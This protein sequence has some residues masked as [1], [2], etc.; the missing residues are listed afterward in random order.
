MGIMPPIII[1]FMPPIMFMGI[2]PPI[3]IG[4][5]PPI[6]FMGIMPPIIGFMPI[7]GMFWLGM[8]IGMA[9]A[10]IMFGGSPPGP[11]GREETPSE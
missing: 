11:P 4:F 10:V 9:F 3:I 8:F 6:M 5:M 7:I 2:M 1:G